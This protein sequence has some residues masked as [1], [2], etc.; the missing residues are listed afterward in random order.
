M[1]SLRGEKSVKPIADG[2]IM[3]AMAFYLMV[4]NSAFGNY[5]F[6]K[7]IIRRLPNDLITACIEK[8]RIEK[9]I[10]SIGRGF[11]RCYRQISPLK[12]L[13]FG[14]H[15]R[16]RFTPSCSL[17]ARQCMAIYGFWRSIPRIL[18]RIL[19]CNPFSRGGDDPVISP[20]IR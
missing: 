19:R 9:V 18:W 2:Q 8:M 16:C 10:E 15:S 4:G 11:Y 3:F 20:S 7:M 1:N 17:Y 13:F 12:C 5:F 14:P 6:L